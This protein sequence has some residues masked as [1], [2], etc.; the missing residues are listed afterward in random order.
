MDTISDLHLILLH[1]IDQD[2]HPH[3]WQ[4]AVPPHRGKAIARASPSPHWPLA[5]QDRLA[6]H[7]E[8]STSP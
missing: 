5:D 7:K 8:P 3:A 4:I 6:D 2:V 1:G